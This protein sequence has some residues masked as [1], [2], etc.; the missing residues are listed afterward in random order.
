MLTKTKDPVAERLAAT[1]ARL[2]GEN[3]TVTEGDLIRAGFTRAQI[4][5]H[6]DQAAA[7]AGR[8]VDRQIAA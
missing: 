4:A 1:M 7:L 5:K 6:V 2:A 8:R 3:D